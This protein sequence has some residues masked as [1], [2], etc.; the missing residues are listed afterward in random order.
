MIGKKHDST[1][2]VRL[3]NFQILKKKPRESESRSRLKYNI[4]CDFSQ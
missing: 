4:A 1:T 3:N 2:Y